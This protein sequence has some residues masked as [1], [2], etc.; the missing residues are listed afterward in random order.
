MKV[1]PYRTRPKFITF[2][3]VDAWTDPAGFMELSA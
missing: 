2:T 3:G 1:T